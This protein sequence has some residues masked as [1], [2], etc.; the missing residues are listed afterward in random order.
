MLWQPKI[1]LQENLY[2]KKNEFLFKSL[3]KRKK[4]ST[5]HGTPSDQKLQQQLLEELKTYT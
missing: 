1:L 4:S 3:E 2:I 5:G